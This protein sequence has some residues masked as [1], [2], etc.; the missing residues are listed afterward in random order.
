MAMTR[1]QTLKRKA[2]EENRQTQDCSKV[3]KRSQSTTTLRKASR[4]TAAS[5]D[6]RACSVPEITQ[7]DV[8]EVACDSTQGPQ[9]TSRSISCSTTASSD[10]KAES[11]PRITQGDV[12]EVVRNLPQTPQPPNKKK[13]RAR[14]RRQ[15]PDPETG[16][17]WTRVQWRVEKT[18]RAS[19]RDSLEV[20]V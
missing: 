6:T 15:K 19:R 5:S 14:A 16:V 11:V 10:A 17:V 8:E 7:G 20:L 4:G 13:A 1:S 12:E 3:L 9:S 18:R 2:S